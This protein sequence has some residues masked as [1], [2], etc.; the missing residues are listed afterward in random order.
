MS[1]LSSNYLRNH[2]K[3]MSSINKASI[4]EGDSSITLVSWSLSSELL[5]VVCTDSLMWAKV[6]R[7]AGVKENFSMPFFMSIFCCKE[8]QIPLHLWKLTLKYHLQKKLLFF[9]PFFK[10]FSINH[11][12][13]VFSIFAACRSNKVASLLVAFL[14]LREK[15]KDLVKIIHHFCNVWN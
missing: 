3:C 10:C 14:Y 4:S 1:N 13:A 8:K 2:R 6:R 7:T 9:N 11:L 12:R 5:G 15:Q